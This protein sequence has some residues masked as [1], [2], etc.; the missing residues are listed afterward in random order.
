MS[1]AVKIRRG[2]GPFWGTLKKVAKGVRRFH[3]PVA[4]PTRPLFRLLY[5]V[6]VGVREGLAWFLRFFW[7]EPLFRSQC[8]EVG[9]GFRLEKLP[10]LMGKGRIVLGRQMCLDG[11]VAIGF[12]NRV[13]ELPELVVGDDVF[14]GSG[15]SLFAADSIRIGNHVLIAGDVRI[16]DFDGHP[17]DAERRRAKEPTP[18]EAIRPIVIGDDVWIGTGAMIMKGVTVG[19]R[20]VVAAASVVTRDVPPDVV[21]AGNPARVV[22]E[23]RAADPQPV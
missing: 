23:L 4:G 2:Q 21:V 7:Y 15:S 14:I 18:A 20:S 17:L 11:K 1:I 3:L 22:K 13:H 5:A 16:A 12:S 19:A 8:A 10:Y 6:H 9:A